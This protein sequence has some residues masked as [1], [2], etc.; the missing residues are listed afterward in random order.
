M[1]N[2]F[3]PLV[4]EK[5]PLLVLAAASCVVTLAVQRSGMQSWAQAGLGPRL[6]NAAVAYVAY[7]WKMLYPADLAVLY[8][9][10]FSPLPAWKVVAAVSVLAAISAAVFA[11]R[12]KCPYL[13][14][15]WLWYLGMLVP[16]IGLIQV[17]W[18]S[19]A[20]RYTYLPQ[21]GLYAAFAWGAAD[22]AGTRR[23]RRWLLAVVAPLAVAGFIVC[24]WQQTRN[25]RD[26]QTLWTHALAHT[27]QNP[28]AANNLAWLRATDPDPG[29]RDGAQAVTLAQIPIELS[30]NNPSWLDTLAAAYAEA[31]RFAE[32]VQTAERALRLAVAKGDRSLA[33]AIETHLQ[34]YRKQEP[35]HQPPRR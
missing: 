25:W 22:I 23:Y 10:S 12:R 32:A 26:S 21:I 19:M 35:Y 5:I 20:D 14:F 34:L 24:S 30:P 7:L 15:G 28:I 29:L 16:V 13:L 31:G 8:P 33:A 9:L 4:I 17:G 27:S 18:Q 1:D 6:A 11:V 2:S 3:N